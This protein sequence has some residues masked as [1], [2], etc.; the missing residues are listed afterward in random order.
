[1]VRRRDLKRAELQRAIGII[2]ERIAG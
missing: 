1:M 2:P